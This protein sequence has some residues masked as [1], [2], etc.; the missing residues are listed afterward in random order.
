[1][2]LEKLEE[3]WFASTPIGDD[4]TNR[5]QM[6]LARAHMEKL[7][8]IA[9]FLREQVNN[10]DFDWEWFVDEGEKLLREIEKE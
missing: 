9:I 10:E 6:E 3:R 1:M 5:E 2:K 7:I 4:I 8:K